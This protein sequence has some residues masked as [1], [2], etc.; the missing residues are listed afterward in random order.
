MRQMP[1]PSWLMRLSPS[2]RR[3]S[4]LTKRLLIGPSGDTS[5][6]GRQTLSAL[7]SWSF[8]SWERQGLGKPTRRRQELQRCGKCFGTSMPS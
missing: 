7:L 6:N 8:F 1:Y 2:I 3:S 4:K 5:G